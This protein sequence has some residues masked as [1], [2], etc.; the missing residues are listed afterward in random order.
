MVAGD[1]AAGVD[2]SSARPS[3][4]CCLHHIRTHPVRGW[5]GWP[6]SSYD[7][8]PEGFIFCCLMPL[9]LSSSLCI[10]CIPRACG[11]VLR[12]LLYTGT[13]LLHQPGEKMVRHSHQASDARS[14]SGFVCFFFFNGGGELLISIDNLLLYG[15]CSL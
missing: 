5:L 2:P 15:N 8:Q 1:T 11:W 9:Y 7:A 10:L 13:L 4:C 14:H 12:S 6:H 3:P